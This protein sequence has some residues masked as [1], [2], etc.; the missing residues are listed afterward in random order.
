MKVVHKDLKLNVL[1]LVI[2]YLFIAVLAIVAD[3]IYMF[4]QRYI[5]QNMADSFC[6]KVFPWIAF[7]FNT[8]SN[9]FYFS[10]TEN[11]VVLLAIL[12]LIL[13]VRVIVYLVVWAV[14]GHS[15]EEH[16]K[17]ARNISRFMIFVVL[18]STMYSLMHGINYRRTDVATQLDMDSYVG[19]TDYEDT[20]EWAYYQMI[21]ARSELGED[22]NGVAHMQTS[23]DVAAMDAE[24][25]V[26]LISR[27]HDLGL[28]KNLIRAK[29]VSISSLWSYTDITGMYGIFFGEANINTDYLDVQYLPITIC[30]EICHAKGYAREYDC[31][32][33]AVLA[34]IY[35]PRADFRYAGYYYIFASLLGD[36]KAYADSL[37]VELYNYLA[38]GRI[39][40]VI[41]D[42]RA[43]NEY[44]ESLETGFIPDL[45][46]RFSE[47]VNDA[48]LESNGQTGGT[49]TY[50]V[51]TNFFVN[52]YCNFVRSNDDA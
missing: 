15:F 18:L 10:V 2:R 30:H 6:R 23:F 7:P 32:M 8:V 41:R 51:H 50:Q 25:M 33:I 38:D 14:K 3:S 27:K 52:Y 34:C 5:S 36:V 44:D 13:I 12:A 17:A 20:L 48:F 4:P 49:A 40:P 1:R 28:S 11:M 39:N 24:I 29:A 42:I 43:G 19:Y 22:Y 35:S 47:D 31:N 21:S 16:L 26:D 46:A 37:D 45:I 9:L